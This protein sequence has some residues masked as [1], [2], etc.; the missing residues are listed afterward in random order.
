MPAI[1]NNHHE[2]LAQVASL[3]YE[4]DQSQ[5]EIASEL[6]LS[7]VKVYR[8]LKEAR[9]EGVVSILID[10]PIER[11]RSVEKQLSEQFKLK[12]ALVL[13]TAGHDEDIAVR[14]L[15]QMAA[16]YLEQILEDGMTLSV[17][18]GRTTYEVI[19]AVRP[20]L[21]AHVNVVQ[22]MGSFP[23]ASPE[24][25]SAALARL[26]AQKLGGQ[27]LFLSSPLMANT[28]AEADILR[29]QTLIAQALEASRC[30]D[31][32]LVG[33]GS[34]EASESRYVQAGVIS[35]AELAELKFGG[36]AGDIGGQ[37]FDLKGDLYP[38]PYNQRMIGLT[39][40]E[41]RRIPATAAVAMGASKIDAILGGLRTGV[42]DVL[43][44]DLETAQAVLKADQDPKM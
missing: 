39:L 25:D 7:R 23:F 15:G 41:M 27:V 4:G 38:C 40:E 8:L 31:A 1:A 43:C 14:R 26:L 11:E 10:W 32:L 13:S 6:G 9:Q 12:E 36:A 29:R 30:A 3:Y 21:R 22:A 18:L 34:L 35:P 33:I 2:L 44:T 20:N 16:R 17:C 28:P 5:S 37:F 19:H 24:F 42:I